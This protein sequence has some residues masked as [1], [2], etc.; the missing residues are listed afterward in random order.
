MAT[1]YNRDITLYGNDGEE[2]GSNWTDDSNFWDYVN[3]STYAYRTLPASSGKETTKWIKVKGIQTSRGG[4]GYVKKVYVQVRNVC[5]NTSDVKIY[6]VPVIN[7][8]DGDEYTMGSKS[9]FGTINYVEITSDSAGPGSGNWTYEDIEDMEIKVYCENTNASSTRYCR[10]GIAFVAYTTIETL[11]FCYFDNATDS[12]NNYWNDIEGCIDYPP[13]PYPGEAPYS[14]STA[15]ET[16]CY[17]D[18]P[19]MSGMETDKY[20]YFDNLSVLFERTDIILT[21][22]TPYIVCGCESGGNITLY[23]VFEY[24]NGNESGVKTIP[25]TTGFSIQQ[26]TSDLC[27]DSNSTGT[28]EN[29]YTWSYEDLKNL[30]VRIYSYNPSIMSNYEVY[31][32]SVYLRCRYVNKSYVSVDEIVNEN[33][34]PPVPPDEDPDEAPEPPPGCNLYKY[35][36]GSEASSDNVNWTNP[37]YAYNSTLETYATVQLP[38]ISTKSEVLSFTTNDTSSET[39]PPQI[40][41]I[42]VK[43]KVSSADKEYRMCIRV[44]LNGSSLIGTFYI[45]PTT[46]AITH[47]VKINKY[48]WNWTDVNNLDVTIQAEQNFYPNASPTFYV[49]MVYIGTNSNVY[50]L[51]VYDSSGNLTLGVTDRITRIIDTFVANKNTSGSQTYTNL[52]QRL[53]VGAIVAFAIPL[54]TLCCAHTC[55][56]STTGN[57]FKV[58]YTYKNVKIFNYLIMDS[59]NSQIIVMGW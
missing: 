38:T 18:V 58:T 9:S 44:Y 28:I 53:G 11:D 6:M 54:D 55:E 14:D 51:E 46:S 29:D 48:S 43:C 15:G 36:A 32:D 17:R 1:T 23:A 49:D 12:T 26:I 16:Y 59:C 42:G 21:E 31:I 10:L 47:W 20:L 13:F 4:G 22:I 52:Y 56:V 57:D 8:S 3:Y 33:D 5:E 45:N 39:Y 2:A 35:T 19:A 27:F 50:G 24:I 7:G 34:P 41:Y 25:T 40:V 30:K 37:S